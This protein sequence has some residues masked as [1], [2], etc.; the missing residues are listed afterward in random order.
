MKYIRFICCFSLPLLLYVTLLYYTTTI[1][2]YTRPYHAAWRLEAG[3]Y[4]Y[5]YIYTY[6]YIVSHDYSVGLNATN[7]SVR[8]NAPMDRGAHGPQFGA[9]DC[10]FQDVFVVV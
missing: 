4:I 3:S 5:T 9:P 8:M 1:L 2:Y 6:M 10:F 7:I